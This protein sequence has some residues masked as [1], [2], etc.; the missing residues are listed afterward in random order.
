MITIDGDGH[1]HDACIRAVL[2]AR[3]PFCAC[4]H[5]IHLH[6]LPIVPDR[7]GVGWCTAC[8]CRMYHAATPEPEP[9]EC[10]RC[11]AEER[12]DEDETWCRP[13][14]PHTYPCTCGHG[15]GDHEYRTPMSGPYLFC[16]TCR[17]DCA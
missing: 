12:G 6:A 11:G 13:D 7:R 16:V 9:R 14:V 2:A 4:T 15:S 17:K 3:G 1:D 10:T 8:D 5:S